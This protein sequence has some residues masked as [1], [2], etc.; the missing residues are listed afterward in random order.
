VPGARSR[1]GRG[2]AGEDHTQDRLLSDRGGEAGLTP[3]A[4]ATQ[5]AVAGA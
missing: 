1:V 5:N 4:R 2:Q 3:T